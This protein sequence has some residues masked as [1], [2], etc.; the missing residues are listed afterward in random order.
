[1]V[2]GKGVFLHLQADK[3]RLDRV[4]FQNLQK[5]GNKIGHGKMQPVN[6]HRTRNPPVGRP[7]GQ[8]SGYLAQYL[9]LQVQNTAG[10]AKNRQKL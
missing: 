2:A 4:L 3:A 9:L 10:F 8:G 6:P 1:M 5:P 7:A